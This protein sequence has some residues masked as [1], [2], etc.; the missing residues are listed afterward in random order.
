MPA[1]INQQALGRGHVSTYFTLEFKTLIED[2]LT[3]LLKD[4]STKKEPIPSELAMKYHRNFYALLADKGFH[5]D[6]KYHW[7]ILRLNGFHHPAEFTHTKQFFIKP[8]LSK[9]DVLMR[10]FRTVEAELF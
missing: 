5:I 7:A 10:V 3:L 2:H 1:G 8:E 6:Y 4:P 9:L